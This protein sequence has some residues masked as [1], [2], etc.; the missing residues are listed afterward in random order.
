MRLVLFIRYFTKPKLSTHDDA[1]R[2]AAVDGDGT[3]EQLTG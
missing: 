1:R 3:D 2:V